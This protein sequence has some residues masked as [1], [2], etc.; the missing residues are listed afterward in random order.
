MIEESAALL[1]GGTAHGSTVRGA[2]SQLAKGRRQSIR[3]TDTTDSSSA[4]QR[5]ARSP[6]AYRVT[7]RSAPGMARDFLLLLTIMT[8]TARLTRV[9]QRCRKRQ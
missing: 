1:Y 9:A 4:V 5:A 6:T 2:G 7:T 3:T 8:A